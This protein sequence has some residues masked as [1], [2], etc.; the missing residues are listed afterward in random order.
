MPGRSVAGVLHLPCMG[1]S[2]SVSF[3][4]VS[5]ALSCVAAIAAT[6]ITSGNIRAS[7]TG[8]VGFGHGCLNFFI[9]KLINEADKALYRAKRLRGA[10]PL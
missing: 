3:P 7:V 2:L 4:S 1:D 10:L 6:P 9:E 5:I 8:S